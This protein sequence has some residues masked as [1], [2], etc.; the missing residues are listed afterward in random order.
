MK[1][2][3]V[4]FLL[5]S[6]VGAALQS[7]NF[8][9]EFI[10]SVN[11]IVDIQNAGDDRLFLLQKSGVVYICQD[12]ILLSPPFLDIS[13]Q[14]N[15][16]GE[17]GLLGMAF[18]PD[19]ETNGFVFV[20]YTN[21]SNDTRICRFTVSSSDPN[22]LNQS[23]EVLILEVD[24]PYNNHNGGQIQ[25]GPDGYL[26]IGMGDGG[27][28]G[29]PD[30]YGQNTSSLLGK[31]L[32]IDIDN[33][34]P[35]A[36]PSDNPFVSDPSVLDEIYAIGL[37]N[38][39][40]FSF[41]AETN[42]MIIADVGQGDWE[43]I[44]VIP[45]GSGGG[46]NF[47]WRCYEGNE[48]Y[49]STNCGPANDY[50]A[51]IFEYPHNGGSGGFSV[52][53]G[54]VY[55][56]CEYPSMYG[57]YIFA[58]YVTGNWWMMDPATGATQF[59]ADVLEDVAT[60]GFN[61]HGDLFVS[62]LNNVYK[63]KFNNNARVN[64]KVQLEGAASGSGLSQQGLIPEQHPYGSSPYNANTTECAQEFALDIVDWVLVELRDSNN[65]QTVIETRVGLLRADGQ[66]LDADGELG[67][68]FYDGLG[69][70]HHIA[71]NHRS[72]LGIISSS[73]IMI[74]DGANWDFT[75]SQTQAL[76]TDQQA[77]L[78]DGSWAMYGGDYDGNGLI[79]I[80]DFTTWFGNNTAVNAYLN[81]DGDLNGIVNILDFQLWFTNRSLVGHPSMQY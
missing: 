14:T 72:H 9:F 48:V 3:L 80:L 33:A 2:A 18:H 63:V 24:Q 61:Q 71:V 45:A 47:G 10:D 42:D 39:W 81:H 12:G 54:Y 67:I 5:F 6:F 27:S 32:R 55:R 7:Q 59:F 29:D 19:Y 28:G 66:I 50:D 20:N 22:V 77:M 73:P 38:P 40:R 31:M 43:E 23:S 75:T 25:F 13:N 44:D 35:Y 65:P 51:P 58:D 62:D 60:Y 70:T 30:N 56:G 17:R 1:K 16:S 53:G 64:I 74:S 76:G 21:L 46:Q 49:N 69:G 4:F 78:M 79:N 8:E 11:D 34:F 36:I 68:R 41:D 57:Q 37:R 52:T 26:Y 15:D